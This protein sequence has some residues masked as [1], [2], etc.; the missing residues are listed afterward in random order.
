MRSRRRGL[1]EGRAAFPKGS[2]SS[3]TDAKRALSGGGDGERRPVADRQLE[4]AA[5]RDSALIGKPASI[6]VR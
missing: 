2:T 6:G 5:E 1:L 3:E 4:A